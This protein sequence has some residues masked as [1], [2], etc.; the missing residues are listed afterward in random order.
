MG[1]HEV[2]ELL[3]NSVTVRDKILQ[4][5]LSVAPIFV[6]A[7]CD[8]LPKREV[9]GSGDKEGLQ[10]VS[11]TMLRHIQGLQGHLIPSHGHV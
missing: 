6:E 9:M 4:S 8:N 10:E 1:L 7:T 11:Q 2:I 3:A 5:V